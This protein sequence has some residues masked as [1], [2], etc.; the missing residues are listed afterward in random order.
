[1]SRPNQPSDD[2]SCTLSVDGMR[3]EFVWC[4]PG[5][6]IFGGATPPT[7]VLNRSLVVRQVSLSDGF[8]IGICP[9]TFELVCRLEGRGV[10]DWPKEP[11]CPWDGYWY[12]AVQWCDAL[13][14]RCSQQLPEGTIVRLPTEA[15]WEYAC[16]AGT[17]TPWYFGRDE[18]QLAAH[19]WYDVNSAERRAP[20][21]QKLPNPWGI[22][23]LYGNVAE[24]CLDDISDGRD[25]GEENPLVI[26]NAGV[27]VVRGGSFEDGPDLCNSWQRQSVVA[28]SEFGEPTGFRLLIGKPVVGGDRQVTVHADADRA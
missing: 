7:G 24:W 11:K 19:A 4:P 18:S 13:T 21:G 1:M 22:Y 17:S 5:E 8:W 26:T 2:R 27:K 12:S 10:P 23:D 9:V 14:E 28:Y 6:F 3:L 16:R 25:G 20:V 15:E